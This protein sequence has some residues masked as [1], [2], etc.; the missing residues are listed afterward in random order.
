[1]PR[2][3]DIIGSPDPS[4]PGAAGPAPRA[5]GRSL[6]LPRR[7]FLRGAA[8]VAGGAIAASAAGYA[9]VAAGVSPL[10]ATRGQSF[11]QEASMPGMSEAAPSA[12][13]PMPE[14]T[15]PPGWSIHDV[16]AMI[17]VQRFV[18]KLALPLGLA[19][20]IGEPTNEP[21]F[22][23]VPQGNQPLEPTIDG[24]WKQFDL[25]VDHIEWPIDA[26][27]PPVKAL[28][29]NGTWPG[30]AIRVTEGDKVRVNFTNRLTETTAVHFH[31][32]EFDDFRMD[33][34]PFVTQ[35][36]ITPGQTWT[37]EFVAR[38]SG[39]HMYHS[40]HNA[41]EQ[42][43]HGLLGAFIVD[44]KDPNESYE[45]KYGV[46]KDVIFIHNDSLGGFT[47]NGHGFPA[48][49]PIVVKK[50]EKVLIRY[51]NE[52]VMMH[53]WHTHGFRQLVVARDG[54]Q[55][56]VPFLAD[57]LGVNP[58]ERWDVIV[59]ADRVGVWAFHCHIL[60]HVEGLDGMYGMVT[61]LVVTE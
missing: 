9:T 23:T 61:A 42:V 49:V 1:M 6:L 28:G 8:A 58:G 33:G 26:V 4:I 43:G 57:T 47:I 7:T 2:M 34:V 35:L 36:P 32:I 25:T 60:P 53:P 21:E 17:K 41:T 50:G 24:D 5:H 52:G 54:A 48:T 45:R 46:T 39:S 18:G 38:P 12:P 13:P 10:G 56:E 16:A 15:I 30:P 11:D 51:M 29:Y 27:I 44:P 37:Y 55:F 31:G 3:R 40:H 20:F 14:A 59:S 19:P 22:T